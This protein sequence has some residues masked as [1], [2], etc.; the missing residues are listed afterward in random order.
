M[1]KFRFDRHSSKD[2]RF[3]G[4][5]RLG[6]TRLRETLFATTANFDDEYVLLESSIMQSV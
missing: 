4:R 6:L 2:I 5:Q 3:Y 1:L